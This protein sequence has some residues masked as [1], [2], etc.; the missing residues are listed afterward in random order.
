MKMN[1][2]KIF[3]L[4]MLAFL[5]MTMSCIDDIDV[6]GSSIDDGMLTFTITIPGP[7]KVE[8]R[9]E[10]DDTPDERKINH[11]SLF[12]YDN[13]GQLV[14]GVRDIEFT[15]PEKDNDATTTVTVALNDYAREL[16]SNNGDVT[17]YLIA[18]AESLFTDD[19]I[20]TVSGL[21]SIV[22]DSSLPRE[23]GF[24]MSGKYQGKLSS[25]NLLTQNIILYRTEAKVSIVNNTDKFTF[26][27][28]ALFRGAESGYVAAGSALKEPQKLYSAA[29][30]DLTPV[31]TANNNLLYV[32]PVK[33]NQESAKSISV[34]IG[35][36][37]GDGATTYYRIDLQQTDP[38]SNKSTPL[39][40]K[41]NHWYEISV[42]KVSGQGYATAEEAA[43]HPAANISVTIYDHAPEVFDMAFDGIH[44]LGVKDSLVYKGEAKGT[45]DLTVKYYS[46]NASDMDTAPTLSTDAGF[47]KITNIS[48]PSI[49]S[50]GDGSE[51]AGRIATYTVEFIDDDETG[52]LSGTINV[53]W[54]GLERETKVIWSRPFDGTAVC[55]ASLKIKRADETVYNTINDYWSF[56]K[57]DVKGITSEKMG[58]LIRNQGFHF[59]IMY[60]NGK[61]NEQRWNYSYDLTFKE[62]ISPSDY[63]CS[64]EIKGDNSVKC[65]SVSKGQSG[66]CF[67]LSLKRPGN[68]YAN[69]GTDYEYGTGELIVSF[70]PKEGK[71]VS[72]KQYKL[73]LYHT[74]FFHDDQG[75]HS[76]GAFTK[77]YY[78]YEVLPVQ[79]ADNKTRYMLDRNI[80]ATAAGMY[81]LNA[82]GNDIMQGTNPSWPFSC[83][84][85]S[86]GARFLVARN[87]GNFS[88]IKLYDNVT[89]PGY[90]VPYQKLWDAVRSNQNFKT[91][92]ATSEGVAYYTA[93][94]NTRV[95]DYLAT[96]KENEET[97]RIIY[98]PKARYIDSSG[99]KLGDANT[100][101]YWTGTEAFGLEKEQIGEW[102][103]TLQ[104]TGQVTNYI[105][106][107]VSSDV[108]SLRAVNNIDE[109]TSSTRIAFKVKG[110]TNVFMYYGNKNDKMFTTTWPGHAIG[111]YDTA[112]DHTFD[113]VYVS[114]GL[115]AQDFKV[116]FTYIDKNNKIWIVNSVTCNGKT[117]TNSGTSLNDTEGIPVSDLVDK[118]VVCTKPSGAQ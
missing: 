6:P 54:M 40:I 93:Q 81:I 90:R 65:I 20:K 112:N 84:E 41:P 5:S 7:V 58:G 106:G 25:V 51:T 45:M 115:T 27:N 60:G 10:K 92:P 83:G 75:N 89:P 43:K 113:F 46:K 14:Q 59:P 32:Y 66:N 62:K 72:E 29:V 35:G 79:G 22:T 16:S 94:Y 52:L 11:L 114:S 103:R 96:G 49:N 78:Y 98:F 110:A 82:S 85:E 53:K 12:I 80:G 55:N 64:W 107:N 34:V 76:V 48:N 118:Y 31:A 28:M 3:N 88:G 18:N 74:G 37:Y 67:T 77:G 38:A 116:I 71:S 86:A 36:K 104:I 117:Y 56:L 70:K 1:I 68:V 24:L 17:L 95:K 39:D 87:K 99:K 9:A 100:G 30:T 23:E 101:Y 4:L 19:N 69:S 102:I 33:N 21:K 109:S 13:N 26:Q 111:N 61:G 73:Q 63:D 91:E 44:E 2:F 108:M 47:I 42:D 8:T 57:T 97:P 15:K 105:N 50:A